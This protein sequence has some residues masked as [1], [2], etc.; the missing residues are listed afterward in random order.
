MRKNS[1]LLFLTLIFTVFIAV[2]CSNQSSNNDA[3]NNEVESNQSNE[4]EVNNSEDSANESNSDDTQNDDGT[5]TANDDESSNDQTNDENEQSDSSNDSASSN[6]NELPETIVIDEQIQHEEGVTFTL[7]QI[8]FKEDHIT[9]DF[10][11]ENFTGYSQYLASAGRAKGQ[12]LGGIT[13]EDDTGF[14][15]RYIA[16]ED[17]DRIEL[18]DQEKVT[19]T[20][21]FAGRIQEDATSLTLIFNPDMSLKFSFEDIEIE[22]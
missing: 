16:D 3:E 13:L 9:V 14:D 17:S 22:W 12:N 21:S 11:A 7:E 6:N 20:V 2:A 15:Y 4:D 18:E 10:N 5:D 1:I 19:G 8:N